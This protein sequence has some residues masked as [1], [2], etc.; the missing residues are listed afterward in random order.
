MLEVLRHGAGAAAADL[1]RADA[2]DGE[3]LLDRAGDESLVGAG[4]LALQRAALLNGEAV[5][6]RL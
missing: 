5:L 6:P 3:Y 1:L 2:H 4:E